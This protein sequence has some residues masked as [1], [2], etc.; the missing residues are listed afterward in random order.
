MVNEMK[1]SGGL[2]NKGSM[3][4]RDKCLSVSVL[5]WGMICGVFLMKQT[6]EFGILSWN[7]R[8]LSFQSLFRV[9]VFKQITIK[10]QTSYLWN[11][12]TPGCSVWSDVPQSWGNLAEHFLKSGCYRTLHIL[13]KSLWNVFLKMIRSCKGLI[14]RQNYMKDKTLY[15][16]RKKW[17]CVSRNCEDGRNNE[18]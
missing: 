10:T 3:A 6:F 16:Q 11:I 5:S 14:E 8:A 17:Q 1:G 12:I 9:Q 7:G 13:R 2:W 18:Y 15:L 4:A